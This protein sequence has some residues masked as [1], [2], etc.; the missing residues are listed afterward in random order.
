MSL[1]AR[2]NRNK[3]EIPEIDAA[4]KINNKT[5]V[6]ITI[7]SLEIPKNKLVVVGGAALALLDLER[8]AN[9]VDLLVH[10]DMLQYLRD[11]GKLPNDIT[12]TEARGSHPDRPRFQ[13]PTSP[14]P[15]EFLSHQSGFASID[16]DEFVRT[17][18][19]QGPNGLIIQSPHVLLQHKRIPVR[20]ADTED[21]R[22][23]KLTQDQYDVSLLTR[24]I[25]STHNRHSA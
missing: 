17:K 20:I 12:V 14:L 13:A 1:F 11:V 7:E 10:P 4:S 6:H 21:E 5:D 3:A 25:H 8:R 15:T 18:T 19:I 9:D 23:R 24:H 22:R 2:R 16:F